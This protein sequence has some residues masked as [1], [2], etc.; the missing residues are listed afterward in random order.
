M[1][2]DVIALLKL[3][4]FI[5]LLLSMSESVLFKGGPDADS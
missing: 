5:V 2:P 4:C 3:I 1:V